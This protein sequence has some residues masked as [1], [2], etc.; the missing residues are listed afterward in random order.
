MCECASISPGS[1]V[2]PGRSITRASLG[3]ETWS[4]G[5][6]RSMRSPRMST[7]QPVW[8]SSVV[9]SNT[10]SG[11]RRIGL[12]GSAAASTGTAPRKMAKASSE[13]FMV[14]PLGRRALLTP[15]LGPALFIG[16]LGEVEIHAALGA[17]A[18]LAALGRPEGKLAP[19]IRTLEMKLGPL[20]AL[21]RAL[22]P[23]HA[24]AGRR[25]D[26]DDAAEDDEG[27]GRLR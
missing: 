22:I 25:Q 4:A 3:M 24:P 6:A 1:S 16:D 8:V 27:H 9:P 20:F 11:L 21:L 5:P 12:A 15:S 2:R 10:R 23:I 26:E 17:L 7:T 19:T 14:P 13:L 18:G